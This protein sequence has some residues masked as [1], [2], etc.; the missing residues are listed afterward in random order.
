MLNP[1]SRAHRAAVFAPLALFL[2][3]A[4][5]L[6]VLPSQALAS[7]AVAES[8]ASSTESAAPERGLSPAPVRY[9]LVKAL[10]QGATTHEAED[11]AVHNARSLAAKHLASLGGAHDLAPAPEGQR[12]VNLKHFPGMGFGAARAV[13]LMELR[14][15]GHADSLP[16]DAKLLTLRASAFDGVLTLEANRPCEAVAAYA[17][18][19]GADPEF[20]PAGVQVFRLTPGKSVKQTLPAG[21]S[22]LSVLACTGGLTIPANPASL[23]EAFTKARAGRPRPSQLEGVVSDCVEQRISPAIG[24]ARAMR[25]KSSEPPVNMTGAAGREGG[26]PVPP[27]PAP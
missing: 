10:G 17:P 20:L 19:T 22:S 26:L 25:L 23:D 24:G 3:V 16:A 1:T 9:L 8:A 6:C 4:L 21:V 7:Q 5:F 11:Q 13:V 18:T 27:K 15:R 2:F 12:V 14:L